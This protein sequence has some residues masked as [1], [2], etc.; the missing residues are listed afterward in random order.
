M[1]EASSS[2]SELAM[3]SP[4]SLDMFTIEKKI[5]KGMFSEV[6]VQLDESDEYNI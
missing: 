2:S 5:G 6:G 4:L 3:P 1:A